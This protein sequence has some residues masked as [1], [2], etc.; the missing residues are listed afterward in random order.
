[1]KRILKSLLHAF[2]LEMQVYRP[3][4][5]ASQPVRHS[6]QACLQQGI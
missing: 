1:M 5:R 6:F 3:S 2:G 4:S